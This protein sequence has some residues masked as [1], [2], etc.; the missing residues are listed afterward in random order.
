[1]TAVA[2]EADNID[3]GILDWLMQM[4][5]RH[6]PNDDVPTIVPVAFLARTSTEDRQDPTL[7]IPRQLDSLNVK[8]PPGFVIVAHFYDTGRSC[9]TQPPRARSARTCCASCGL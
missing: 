4:A 5:D 8:L 6:R 3:V 9:S 1:M 2:D 7:A